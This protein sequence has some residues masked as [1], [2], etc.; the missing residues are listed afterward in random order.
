MSM[1]GDFETLIQRKKEGLRTNVGRKTPF[2]KIAV[3]QHNY[4]LGME[5]VHK[6]TNTLCQKSI[7]PLEFSIISKRET[8]GMCSILI[9]PPRNT[10]LTECKLK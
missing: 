7:P 3:Q 6:F 1:A 5:D 10:F 4:N 2:A 9:S 8:R